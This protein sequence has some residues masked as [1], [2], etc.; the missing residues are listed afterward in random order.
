MTIKRVLSMF[1]AL[2]MALAMLPAIAQAELSLHLFTN[3]LE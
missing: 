2:I 1:L 3:V